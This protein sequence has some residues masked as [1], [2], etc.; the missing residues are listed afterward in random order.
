MTDPHK[1]APAANDHTHAKP[2]AKK[3]VRPAA[4]KPAIPRVEIHPEAPPGKGHLAAAVAVTLGAGALIGRA[5]FGAA[6]SLMR[7]PRWR[8][9]RR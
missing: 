1:P 8:R 3:T 7:H 6:G 9:W 2:A 5:I 4:P